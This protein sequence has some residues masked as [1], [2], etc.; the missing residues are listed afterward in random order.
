MRIIASGET[1]VADVTLTEGKFHQVKRMF[2][3]VGREVTALHRLTFGSLRLDESLPEGQWRELTER[4]AAALY[5]AAQ[6]KTGE[7]K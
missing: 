3:A 2:S 1:S 5:A 7:E 4:E 6:M